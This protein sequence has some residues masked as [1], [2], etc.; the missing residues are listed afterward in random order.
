VSGHDRCEIEEA[1]TVEKLIHAANSFS[2]YK[3]S[4]PDGVHPITLQKVVEIIPNQI[5]SL[6]RQ[7]LSVGYVPL[8]W[9]QSRVIFLPKPGKPDYSKPNSWRP[10]SLTSF[11]LKT[12][13]RLIDKRIRTHEMCNY[14]VS[15][16]QFAYLPGVSTETAISRFVGYVEKCRHNKEPVM[17]A[18]ADISG[19]FNNITVH[20]IERSLERMNINPCYRRWI[21][22]MLRHRILTS[23]LMGTSVTIQVARG[24]PQ[25]GV[26]SPILWNLVMDDLLTTLKAKVPSLFIQAF[27]D[28]LVI[29]QQGIDPGTIVERVC[30]GLKHTGNWCTGSGL[31][32]NPN[33]TEVIVFNRRR[34]PLPP[35]RL[36]GEILTPKSVVRYLGVTMD[37]RLT[38]RDHVK[39]KAS[40]AANQFSMCKRVVGRQWGFGSRIMLWLYTAVIRPSIDYGSVAWA[41]TAQQHG[42]IRRLRQVQHG[43]CLA[44]TGALKSTPTEAMECILGLLPLDIHVQGRALASWHRLGRNRRIYWDPLQTGCN[45]HIIIIVAY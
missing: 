3:S 18:L 4:G 19:A 30:Q 7:C 11:F 45:S 26:L 5:C 2:P 20:S 9:R 41:H 39:L 10:I 16:N 34:S 15:N 8:K 44:I 6:M 37:D 21:S 24:C 17:A 22:F 14:L 36:H 35:L 43:A 32:L 12:L 40:K 25:G 29:A 1:V 38:L 33:K 13:E 31:E 28:D 27:A 23:E 42:V